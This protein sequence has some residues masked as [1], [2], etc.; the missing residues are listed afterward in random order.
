MKANGWDAANAKFKPKP[1]KHSPSPTLG[2]FFAV[3]EKNVHFNPK[4]FASYCH[5]F[6]TI[7]AGITGI[8]ATNAGKIQGK[9]S[10]SWR[11]RIDR[12]QLAKVCQQ[13]CRHGW[14]FDCGSHNYPLMRG[15]EKALVR[16]GRVCPCA[17]GLL[18]L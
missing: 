6:R 15:P 18:N 3:V 17:T 10:V 14:D 13:V 2:E 16:L 9:K 8:G 11:A 1:E 7:V 12:L 4:T 5:R